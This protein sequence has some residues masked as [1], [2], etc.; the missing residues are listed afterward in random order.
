MNATIHTEGM[1]ATQR[2]ILEN[3]MRRDSKEESD[4]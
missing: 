1:T 3:E 2:A 4:G